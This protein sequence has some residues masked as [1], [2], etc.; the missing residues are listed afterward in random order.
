MSWKDEIKVEFVT[1]SV[2]IGG[3]LLSR[4][5]DE[6]LLKLMKSVRPLIRDDA[7][8]AGFDELLDAFAMGPPNTTLVRRMIRESKYDELRD[9]MFGQFCLKDIDLEDM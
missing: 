8:R 6:S 9:F 4:L 5:S 3:G 7:M 1:R 2:L